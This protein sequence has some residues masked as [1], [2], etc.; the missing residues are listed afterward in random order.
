MPRPS[1][2]HTAPSTTALSNIGIRKNV[3]AERTIE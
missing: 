2:K 3:L 1:T